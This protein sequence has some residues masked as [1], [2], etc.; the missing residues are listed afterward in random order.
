VR[1]ATVTLAVTGLGFSPPFPPGRPPVLPTA[2]LEP[3]GI[4]PTLTPVSDSELVTDTQ[5]RLRVAIPADVTIPANPGFRSYNLSITSIMGSTPQPDREAF[6]LVP[7]ADAIQ[8]ATFEQKSGPKT[9][10]ATVT[11]LN[12]RNG[13]IQ[14]TTPS[15]RLED[16]RAVAVLVVAVVDNQSETELKLRVT[17]PGSPQPPS[18]EDGKFIQWLGTT[19]KISL[20]FTVTTPEGI[21]STIPATFTQLIWKERRP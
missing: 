14:V 5:L 10:D 20:V 9:I 4:I 8:P 3:G 2:R 19:K 11:G 7:R 1:G 17:V 13:S 12:L 15:H 21:Q 6:R 18:H 16:Q